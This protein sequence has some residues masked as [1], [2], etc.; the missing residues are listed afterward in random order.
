MSLRKSRIRIKFFVW[1]DGF[2]PHFV[3]TNVFKL[4]FIGSGALLITLWTSSN[5]FQFEFLGVK[6]CITIWAI[7][8]S[9]ILFERLQF[10]QKLK[11]NETSMYSN[12]I[13]PKV[14]TAVSG[15]HEKESDATVSIKRSNYA[16]FRPSEPLLSKILSK[17]DFESVCFW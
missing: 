7:E 10:K 6:K 8:L 11:M 9:H 14:N 15:A 16:S 4:N 2:L 17:N 5:D 3:E 13:K 12:C 1:N